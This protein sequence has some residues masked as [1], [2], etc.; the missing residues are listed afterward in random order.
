MRRHDLTQTKENDK[1]KDKYR[2]E[3]NDNDS[4]N[5]N[6]NDHDNDNEDDNGNDKWVTFGNWD[7]DY[8]SD[9]WE[10]VFMTI[11]VAWQLRVTLDSI[12]NSCDV[13][14]ESR[15]KK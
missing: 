14:Y 2:Y 11:F 15:L 5:D 12:R 4:Y 10:P 3:D 9:N 7:T 8:N 13:F 1:D 6:Y